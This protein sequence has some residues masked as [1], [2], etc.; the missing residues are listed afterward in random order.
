M[1]QTFLRSILYFSESVYAISA[2]RHRLDVE[3]FMAQFKIYGHEQFLR[4]SAHAISAAIH[5]ASV[6]ALGLPREKRF[7]RFLPLEPWQFVTPEDR[8]DRYLII[9]VMMFEGRPEATLK[10]LYRQVL[11]NLEAECEINANDIELVVT[12][13][14]RKHWLIRGLPADELQLNYQVDHSTDA[15]G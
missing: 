12:E 3:E 13:S 5:R 2:V 1:P 11:E 4:D 9:E 8:S 14:P 7:H 6:S 15:P 10:A